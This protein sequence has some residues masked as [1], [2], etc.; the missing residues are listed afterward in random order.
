[1]CCITGTPE[2]AHQVP[3][4]ML[5]AVPSMA[6]R[7]KRRVAEAGTTCG[8]LTAADG[9]LALRWQRRVARDGSGCRRSAQRA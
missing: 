5:V 1:M 8:V 6:Q 4:V 3:A 7:W 2:L 9:R